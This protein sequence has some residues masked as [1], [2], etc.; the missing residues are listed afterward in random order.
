[1]Q[2]LC[3]FKRLCEI[4]HAL[5]YYD[6][7]ATENLVKKYNMY[8]PPHFLQASMVFIVYLLHLSQIN[9]YEYCTVVQRKNE[10]PLFI[11]IQIIL[12]K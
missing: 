11:S 6:Y 5:D 12:Q 7:I 2:S 9:N 8:V 1:M 3:C 4:S 10:T